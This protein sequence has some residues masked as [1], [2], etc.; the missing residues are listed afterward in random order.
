MLSCRLVCGLGYLLLYGALGPSE[1]EEVS[2]V[3]KR[4]QDPKSLWVCFACV[5]V[6]NAQ[7][8]QTTR[9]KMCTAKDKI[10]RH[11]RGVGCGGRMPRCLSPGF[12]CQPLV[13]NL[14]N[15]LAIPGLSRPAA[16]AQGMRCGDSSKNGELGR[17]MSR[18]REAG[19]LPPLDWTP[20]DR[21]ERRVC[22]RACRRQHRTKRR[23]P[24]GRFLLLLLWRVRGGEESTAARSPCDV[25][26]CSRRQ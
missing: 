6:F 3:Q 8:A 24:P 20:M 11:A 12:Y 2:T 18:A 16:T 9:I 25:L 4:R 5:C 22:E 23:I 15:P 13:N 19:D 10:E 7:D 14:C 17:R 1:S 21:R 26:L